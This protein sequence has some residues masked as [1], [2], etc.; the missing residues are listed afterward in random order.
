[1]RSRRV[2]LG[3]ALIIR[4]STEFR[5]GSVP[6]SIVA[7]DSADILAAQLMAGNTKPQRDEP[8]AFGLLPDISS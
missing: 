4:H 7:H 8:S 1:V 6:M 5:F 3:L 2:T